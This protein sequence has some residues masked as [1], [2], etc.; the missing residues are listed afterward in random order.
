MFG[1]ESL[2]HR[3]KTQQMGATYCHYYLTIITFTTVTVPNK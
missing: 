2:Q 3:V 1:T